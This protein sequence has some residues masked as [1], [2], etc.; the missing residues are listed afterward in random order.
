MQKIAGLSYAQVGI[1]SSLFRDYYAGKVQALS[2]PNPLNIS[3]KE[4]IQNRHYDPDDRHKLAEVIRRQYGSMAPDIEPLLEKLILPNTFTITT[5]HQLVLA[6]GPLYFFYKIATVVRMARQIQT[7]N[8][9]VNIIPVFWMNSEDHDFEE[10]NHFY[11]NGQK[12]S[13]ESPLRGFATGE[14]P[15]QA[16]AD[17]IQQW[18]ATSGF[19]VNPAF[20]FVME[21]YRNSQNQSEAMRKIIHHWMGH[22]GIICLDQQ[23]PE[24]KR[25][26]AGVFQKEL[27]ELASCAPVKNWSDQLCKAGYTTQVQPRELN[28]FYHHP[29]AGRKRIE[30]NELGWRVVDTDL[31]FSNRE[32]LLE[33]LK[34]EPQRFSTNVVTRPLYQERVLPNLAYVGGPAEVHYWLQYF[35]LFECFELPFPVVLMRESLV[36]LPEKYWKKWTRLGLSPEDLFVEKQSL[37]R[38]FVDEIES[39]SDIENIKKEL[40]QIF[41]KQ[42]ERALNA[43]PTLYAWTLAQGRRAENVLEHVDQR[44]RSAARKK[45]EKELQIIEQTHAEV[46]PIG[47]FQERIVN[48]L[49]ITSDPAA[50][51]TEL[52]NR[53]AEQ[54]GVELYSY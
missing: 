1:G 6:T 30:R 18:L 27:L 29:S 38:R 17:A 22:E 10:T 50:F 20:N 41:E 26:A 19:P 52:V 21:A 16:A 49:Q 23:D 44:L 8:P 7:E 3:W 45:H 24:L 53:P 4:R 37:I 11:I 35:C 25:M 33:E 15:A 46:Y 13:W 54:P 39:V 40:F 28:L 36:L 47:V 5:G 34:R 9:D 12:I 43:D 51:F 14:M 31:I 2:L 32:T 42:A 48:I